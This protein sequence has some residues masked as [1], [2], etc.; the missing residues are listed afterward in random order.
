MP[1]FADSLTSGKRTVGSLRVSTS[2][3]VSASCPPPFPPSTPSPCTSTANATVPRHTPEDAKDDL[4][5]PL[6]LLRLD[7]DMDD[8]ARLVDLKRAV[9]L[10]PLPL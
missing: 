10:I 2:S 5:L 6:P 7:L 8:A 3:C 1:Y 4:P 9:L